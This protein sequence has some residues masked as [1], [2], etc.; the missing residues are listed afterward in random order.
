MKSSKT[1]SEANK[2]REDA[3]KDGLKADDIV[4]EGH[5]RRSQPPDRLNAPPQV[6]KD[7]HKNPLLFPGSSAIMTL[8]IKVSGDS[9]K[10]IKE[11]VRRTGRG[12]PGS[13]ETW[14]HMGDYDDRTGYGTVVLMPTADHQQAHIGGS[15]QKRATDYGGDPDRAA[16][17]G[18][19]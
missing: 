17:Y 13:G 16:K 7:R 9:P 4:S 18:Y 3:A 10:D 12:K 8:Q 19:S 11:L 14:H 6:Q 15:A 2:K 5:K 1:R